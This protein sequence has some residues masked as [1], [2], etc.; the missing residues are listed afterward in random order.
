MEKARA[1]YDMSREGAL[2]LELVEE[3]MAKME[4]ML[5]QEKQKVHVA[6]AEALTYKHEIELMKKTQ[7]NCTD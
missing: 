6:E 5:Q 2:E 3:R 1:A 7:Y 4:I